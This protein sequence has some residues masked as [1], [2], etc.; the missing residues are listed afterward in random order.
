MAVSERFLRNYWIGASLAAGA[1]L[2][3]AG[4]E[5]V[6]WLGIMA[7]VVVVASGAVVSYWGWTDLRRREM[8]ARGTAAETTPSHS[9]PDSRLVAGGLLNVGLAVAAMVLVL[10]EK[11][12]LAIVTGLVA[13]ATAGALWRRSHR[14]RS[15][16]YR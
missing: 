9:K 8:A 12:G 2:A 14:T 13:A 4:A 5:G 7:F 6:L 11:G 1:F 15:S 3:L 16:T 10:A